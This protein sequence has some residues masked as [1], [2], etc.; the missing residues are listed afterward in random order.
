M[1]LDVYLKKCPDLAA[2]VAAESAFETE[3]KGAWSDSVS[4]ETRDARLA[5]ASA[6]HGTD[7]WGTHASRQDVEGP[8]SVVDS[9]HYFKVGYFR[10]SY[11]ESGLNRVL[12][13]AGLIGLGEIMGAPGDG[14]DFTPDW[15]ACLNRV[16][17]VIEK[18]SA[19]LAGDGGKLY[20]TEIRPMYEHGVA[21]EKAA[22]ACYLETMSKQPSFDGGFINRD[23]EFF[24]KGQTLRAVITKQY[25]PPAHDD[26]IGRIINR[27]TVFLVM[28]K[29]DTGKEDWHLTALRIV[30]ETIEYVM[31]QPDRAHYY[32]SWSG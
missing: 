6:K 1:G 11:N 18:Y 27:P 20:V 19:F 13:K 26:L 4:E 14:D 2:A 32:L 12:S 30:K 16:N 7:E 5:A 21:D 25:V 22:L 15:D 23:G 3:T 28:D 17:D 31:A 8:E 10:S 9:D 29:E 24:P